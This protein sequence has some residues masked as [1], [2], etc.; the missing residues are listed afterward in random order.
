[1]KSG[2]RVIPGA[3]V[4]FSGREGDSMLNLMNIVRNEE[5]EPVEDDADRKNDEWFRKAYLDLIE[6]YPNSWVAVCNQK[7][8]AHAGTRS[9]AKEAVGDRPCSFY[10][11]EPSDIRTGLS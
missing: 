5:E 3:D 10:F 7:V 1:M 11:I 2:A 4:C 8:I 6:D 9:G